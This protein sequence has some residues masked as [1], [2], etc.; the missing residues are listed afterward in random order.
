M[1]KYIDCGTKIFKN[2]GI[3]ILILLAL[4]ATYSAGQAVQP[5]NP[6]TTD[7]YVTG[8]ETWTN[9]VIIGEM[10]SIHVNGSLTL[11]GIK[12][13]FAESVYQFNWYPFFLEKNSS[14]NFIN[15][16]V[17]DLSKLPYDF[18]NRLIQ[19]D[20]SS[21]K[22]KSIL[23][24]H[25]EI[26]GANITKQ[27]YPGLFWMSA[28][29]TIKNSVIKNNTFIN[30]ADYSALFIV[31]GENIIIENSEFSN[32]SITCPNSREPRHIVF[33]RSANIVVKDCVFTENHTSGGAVLGGYYSHY[34]PG[35]HNITISG[36]TFS[37]NTTADKYESGTFPNGGAVYLIGNNSMLNITE[38]NKF[39]QNAGQEKGG[40]LQIEGSGS[41]LTIGSNNLF[42]GNSAK[43]GGAIFAQNDAKVII[44]GQNDIK[45]CKAETG[46]AIYLRESELEIKDNNF[47]TRNESLKEGGAICAE[48]S[49]VIIEGSRFESNTSKGSGGALY[50]QYSKTQLRNTDFNRN[51]S[52]GQG[53]AITARSGSIV[54][55][56]AAF[57]QNHA[58]YSGGAMSIASQYGYAE[59]AECHII[60]ADFLQNHSE[61]D[62]GAISID[63]KCT[64]RM[65]KTAIYENHAETGGGIGG[66]ST[67]SI[68]IY[69]RDGAAI[70]HN[71]GETEEH[72][73]IYI[74]MKDPESYHF[75]ERMFNGGYHN[76]NKTKDNA[77][78]LFHS[79]PT[80]EA[81]EGALVT[82][83][84]NESKL[85]GGAISN[86]GILEI[87]SESRSLTIRK[88]WED[89]ADRKGRRPDPEQFVKLLTLTENGKERLGGDIQTA[90]IREEADGTETRGLTASG[91]PELSILVHLN[92]DRWET[93]IG[94]LPIPTETETYSYSLS[95][96]AQRFYK[97]AVSGNT[98]SG[99]DI[100]NR[101]DPNEVTVSILT[102]WEDQ[103]D[104]QHLR[105]LPEAYI[106]K[107]A[108]LQD[109]MPVNMGKLSLKEE[110]VDP[111]GTKHLV[112]AAEKDPVLL[113]RVDDAGEGEYSIRFEDLL[114]YRDGTDLSYSVTQAPLQGYET[115][116]TGDM[117]SGFTII[118]TLVRRPDPPAEDGMDF[119][120]LSDRLEK[121]PETG[122][123]V[124]NNK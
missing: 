108:I 11:S 109:G 84:E 10:G 76:W 79:Q 117:G 40:A 77:G 41:I 38:N 73:D 44:E 15:G 93:M 53:G 68:Y 62:G 5:P 122:F 96:Q 39:I 45:S 49:E 78:W 19:T 12:V 18:S 81:A 30:Y 116:L 92:G 75:S 83:S 20:Y 65:D 57:L 114:K 103:G 110:T 36:T 71:H 82:F 13:S 56:G 74:E 106:E 69:D 112:F 42:E 28:E 113:I 7:V 26:S 16:T 22:N 70:F 58:N 50:L 43:F 105:P 91:D 123:P 95:E 48:R 60:H 88:T 17:L 21:D 14:L 9:D 61:G 120:L 29:L 31:D 115:D 54:V 33:T 34:A 124:G 72:Q 64:L 97:P 3:F 2:T 86:L 35:P 59:P 25:A 8:N 102:K 51:S 111:D 63:M 87:G 46:G 98:D 119:Y 4:L 118:N 90:F 6:I 47:F 1:E 24:D 32:N 52:E 121:L 27:I 100:I 37:Y 94:G 55:D 23:F 85:V 99:F 101:Y 80:N 89:N 66:A 67:A 104:R 107:L